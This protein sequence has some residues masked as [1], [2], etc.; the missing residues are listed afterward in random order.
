MCLYLVQRVWTH[1]L[2]D[3]G[4]TWNETRKRCEKKTS[5]IIYKRHFLQSTKMDGIYLRKYYKE[6][7]PYVCHHMYL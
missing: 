7:E 1:K 6:V 5:T 3:V 4:V 2:W